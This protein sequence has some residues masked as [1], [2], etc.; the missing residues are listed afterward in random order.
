MADSTRVVLLLALLATA[1]SPPMIE[2]EGRRVYNPE[3]AWALEVRRS[4][5]QKPEE[6]M[7]ALALPETAV[8]ADIGAGGGYFAERFSRSLPSGHVFATDVQDGM[9]ERLEARVRDRGL[10]N[11]T[12]IRGRFEDPGLAPACC[13][14]VFFS[15][16]YKEIHGRV[17]YMR[18][19]RPV[20]RPGGR[21][22]ILEFRP[23]SPGPGPPDSIRLT[24][25]A[26]VE[27]LRLAGFGLVESHDFLPRQSFLV[28]APAT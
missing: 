5:W 4:S 9:V 7:R 8:V 19:V 11:V 26:I 27:E 20:L 17:E 18:R 21:V 23:G 14:L 22:V 10:E 1:C 16:V 12:V 25:D 28:F 2:V 24:P 6:V 15:S 3:W 13:D